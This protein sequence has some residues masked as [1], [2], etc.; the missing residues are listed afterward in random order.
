M[1]PTSSRGPTPNLSTLLREE[2]PIINGDGSTSRDF[3]YVDNAVQA[4]LL[5]ALTEEA[6]ALNT[7]Y[8]IACNRQTSLNELFQILRDRLAEPR[9]KIGRIEPIYG[10]F[11]PGD[12]LHSLADIGKARKLLGYEPVYHI[13]EGLKKTLTW[14]LSHN[15]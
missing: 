10:P 15:E 13:E 8:N 2:Q 1:I 14:F 11:R 9:A 7:V 6:G 4:N 3:C 5:A 12:V